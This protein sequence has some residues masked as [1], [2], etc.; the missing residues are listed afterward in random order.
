[1]TIESHAA[2]KRSARTAGAGIRLR[3]V[4]RREWLPGYLFILPN[5][6]GFA[7]FTAIPVV[8]GLVMSFTDYDGFAPMQPV[9]FRNY[10]RLLT[11]DYFLISLKNNVI[12]TLASVPLTLLLAMAMALALNRGMRFNSVFKTIFFF[13]TITSMV[14]VA[15][16]WSAMFHPTQGPVNSLLRMIGVTE[17]PGWLV[18]SRWALIAVVCVVVWK[19]AGY[20]MV[21]LLAGLQ[22]IPVHLYESARIDGAGAWARLRHVT[23]P[24]LSPTVFLVTI[25]SIIN[26]FQ[27]FDIVYVMTEGGPGRATNVLVYR[28]YQEAFRN[29]HFG[30]ASAIAFV[31]FLIVFI[32]TLIQFRGQRKWV[33]YMQ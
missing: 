23:M 3:G 29:F 28:I 25:L 2:G 19:G 21:M 31:L 26:S 18:S 11:D 12:F 22:S 13:P 16:L 27:V 32:V 17:P 30:Y 15:I 5:F 20:Y 6:L 1:M 4:S 8:S 9:W 33:H 10:L 14:A 7:I 24:M